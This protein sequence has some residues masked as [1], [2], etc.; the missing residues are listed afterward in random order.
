MSPCD[1]RNALPG[2][3][4]RPS[5]RRAFRIFQKAND[6]G[7]MSGAPLV[8][9]KNDQAEEREGNRGIGG[10]QKDGLHRESSCHQ[11]Y[12]QR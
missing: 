2:T 9:S 12:R 4:A 3:R 10:G 1:K 6:G 11:R 5:S 8:G 7:A